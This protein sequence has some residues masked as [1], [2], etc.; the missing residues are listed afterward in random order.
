MNIVRKGKENKQI[1]ITSVF[2]IYTKNNN[3][4]NKI[5]NERRNAR[6]F[7][8]RIHLI[9]NEHVKTKGMCREL[10]TDTKRNYFALIQ[11]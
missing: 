5:E 7:Q 11:F 2:I 1:L 8:R 4:N 3:N 6:Y 9:N 10:F